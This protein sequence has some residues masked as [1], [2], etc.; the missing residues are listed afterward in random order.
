MWIQPPESP[1]PLPSHPTGTM[2]AGL[3]RFQFPPFPPTSISSDWPLP[4][5]THGHL[6]L[7]SETQGLSF[8]DGTLCRL[9]APSLPSL[10]KGWRKFSDKGG[11]RKMVSSPPPL[12]LLRAQF[13]AESKTGGGGTRW[14]KTK[15]KYH[16]SLIRLAKI[17]RIVMTWA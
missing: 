12:P 7:I 6:G 13:P 2:P 5:V 9:R 3:H 17:I 4:L 8:E 15:M 1:N 14:L 16:F 11:S 10:P